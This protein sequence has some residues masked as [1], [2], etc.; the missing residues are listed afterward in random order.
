MQKFLNGNV[1]GDLK[2]HA[3]EC[4]IEMTEIVSV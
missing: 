4:H 3:Q 2:G 1:E